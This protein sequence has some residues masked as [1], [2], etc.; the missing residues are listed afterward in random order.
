MS[1]SELGRCNRSV[2]FHWVC[3]ASSY[4]LVLRTGT[5]RSSIRLLHSFG[6]HLFGHHGTLTTMNTNFSALARVLPLRC[7]MITSPPLALSL[8]APASSWREE[9]QLLP[10]PPRSSLSLRRSRSSYSFATT[11]MAQPQHAARPHTRPVT[12]TSKRFSRS[13]CS[14]S[15]SRDQRRERADHARDRP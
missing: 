12:V 5:C 10:S 3:G 2:A 4:T 11:V 7:V 15:S 6:R 13:H 14:P 9:H 1:Q 8:L